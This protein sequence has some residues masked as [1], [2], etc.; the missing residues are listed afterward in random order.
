MKKFL[1]LN[2]S[3][4]VFIMLVNVKMP[5]IVGILTFMSRINFVLSWVKHE[6]SFITS[7]PDVTKLH[8]LVQF[9]FHMISFCDIGMHKIACDMALYAIILIFYHEE[10]LLTCLFQI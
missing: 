2:L 6:K 3:D 10:A 5:T 9:T 8:S 7:R 4:V 1:A